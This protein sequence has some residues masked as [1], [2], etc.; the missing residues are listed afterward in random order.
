MAFDKP[1]KDYFSTASHN[2]AVFRPDYPNELYDFLIKRVHHREVAWDCATGNGQ[3][4]CKLADYF[5]Y[6]I[7]TDASIAQIKTAI[8]KPNVSYVVSTAENTPIIPSSIDMITIAQAM[9]WFNFDAFFTEVRRVLKPQGIIA[10]WCYG[11]LRTND[12]KIDSLMHQYYFETLSS[13]WPPERHYI[14]EA[15]QTI[16]FPFERI[17]AP[18]FEIV[19]ELD[20]AHF[21]GYLET[22]S[23]HHAY[24]KQ[25]GSDPLD[26]IRPSLLS[27]WG[28]PTSKKR[29]VWPIFL[30]VGR[31]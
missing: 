30:L 20:L 11:L 5:N 15:Y 27:A 25:N 26:L 24:L 22:W 7:A 3:A 10:A 19:K 28:D 6:V 29:I 1:F 4:A 9:H 16:D 13:Y 23:A 2:Y 17:E 21:I 18:V 31:A 14:D 8:P 12:V